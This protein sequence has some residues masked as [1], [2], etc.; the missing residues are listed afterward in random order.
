MRARRC[1]PESSSI[2]FARAV[3]VTLTLKHRYREDGTSEFGYVGVHLCPYCLQLRASVPIEV[4]SRCGT[5]LEPCER[6]SSNA[7]RPNYRRQSPTLRAAV[8]LLVPEVALS[9]EENVR[10]AAPRWTLSVWSFATEKPEA[11]R[12][13]TKLGMQRSAISTAAKYC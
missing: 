3:A 1:P 9:S 8:R 2:E 10:S 5:V 12:Q 13:M 4:S 6:G 11:Q 7:R